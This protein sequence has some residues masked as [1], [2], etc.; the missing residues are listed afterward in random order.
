MHLPIADF[1]SR[2]KVETGAIDDLLLGEVIRRFVFGAPVVQAARADLA[3]YKYNRTKSQQAV[4]DGI[5]NRRFYLWPMNLSASA[6]DSLFRPTILL[7]EEVEWEPS[8]PET[9]SA[10]S[11]SLRASRR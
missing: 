10:F 7:D 2:L 4:F 9:T 6:L 5:F 3:T 8:P 11:T 1:L